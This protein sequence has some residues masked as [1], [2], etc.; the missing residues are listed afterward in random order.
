MGQTARKKFI[1]ENDRLLAKIFNKEK[2]IGKLLK[3]LIKND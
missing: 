3:L 1:V 2:T